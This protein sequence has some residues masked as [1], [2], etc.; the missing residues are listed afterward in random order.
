ME[1]AVPTLKIKAHAPG[2][3][4]A[5]GDK[6]PLALAPRM[7]NPGLFSPVTPDLEGVLE[8]VQ[9]VKAIEAEKGG[10]KGGM[11]QVTAA[12]EALRLHLDAVA[13]HGGC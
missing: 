3:G 12:A 8:K 2:R 11:D 5:A 10:M 6:K 9:G 1:W 13:H 4:K 7:L